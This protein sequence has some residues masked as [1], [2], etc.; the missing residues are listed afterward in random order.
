MDSINSIND[1]ACFLKLLLDTKFE[2]NNFEKY[3]INFQITP[4]AGNKI[5]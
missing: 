2:L 1:E 3:S 5:A 4:Y